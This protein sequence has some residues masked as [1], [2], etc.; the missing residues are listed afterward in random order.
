MGRFLKSN[1][2]WPIDLTAVVG[3]ITI[4]SSCF[5]HFHIIILLCHWLSLLLLLS[6]S[7]HLSLELSMSEPLFQEPLLQLFFCSC[8]SLSTSLFRISQSDAKSRWWIGHAHLFIS[9]FLISFESGLVFLFPWSF[10]VYHGISPNY[11]GLCSTAPDLLLSQN[12]VQLYLL[13][14]PLLRRSF[15]QNA[16]EL[17]SCKHRDLLVIVN[18]LMRDWHISK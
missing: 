5:F 2:I 10:F 1:Q 17:C 7:F 15:L 11:K 14:S 12:A 8:N 18:S 3:S 9:Y 6:P 16:Q 13:F 4:F